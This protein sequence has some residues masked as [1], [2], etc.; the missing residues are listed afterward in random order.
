MHK[1]LNLTRSAE[2]LPYLYIQFST[3]GPKM[4]IEVVS[5]AVAKSILWRTQRYEDVCV[6]RRY[7]STYRMH[8]PSLF[9]AVFQYLYIQ[10]ALQIGGILH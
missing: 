4:G 9:K 7:R 5:W 10:P 8:L 3:L 1:K 2:I 6:V